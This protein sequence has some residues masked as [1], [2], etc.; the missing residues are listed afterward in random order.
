MQLPGNQGSSSSGQRWLHSNKLKTDY[1]SKIAS[2]IRS[3]FAFQVTNNNNNNNNN[4]SI[5]III[6]I[7]INLNFCSSAA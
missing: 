2:A 1:R 6:I 3:V 5:I 4:N 7:I